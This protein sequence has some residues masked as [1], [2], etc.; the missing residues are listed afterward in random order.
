MLI[1]NRQR[2]NTITKNN[3]LLSFN[4]IELQIIRCEKKLG[5]HL[6]WNNHFQHV[7]KKISSSLW[8]FSQ[9]RSYVSQQDRVLYYNAYIKPHFEYCF[10]IKGNSFDYNL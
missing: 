10:T 6:E 3:W 7:C 2:R 4:D 5:I 8:L 1:S 9:I